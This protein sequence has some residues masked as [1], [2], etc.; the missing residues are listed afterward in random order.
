MELHDRGGMNQPEQDLQ[1]WIKV[2]GVIDSGACES[3]AP[4]GPAPDYEIRPTAGSAAGTGSVVA[5]GNPITN[6]GRR[7][8]SVE[9]NEGLETTMEFTVASV[10]RPLCAVPAITDCGNQVIF[11]K[12]GGVIENLKSGHR[13]SFSRRNGVYVLDFW[14]RPFAGQAA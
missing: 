12:S 2:E 5:N 11:G 4:I 9:T 3:V 10:R 8:L 14:V 1:G 7:K 6:L 13:T